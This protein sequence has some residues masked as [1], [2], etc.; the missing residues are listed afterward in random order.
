MEI[1]Y[2]NNIEDLVEA[3][4]YAFKHSKASIIFLKILTYILPILLCFYALFSNVS[5]FYKVLLLIFSIIFIYFY[6]KLFLTQLK[7]GFRKRIKK[8]YEKITYSEQTLIINEKGI[9][10][11]NDYSSNLYNWASVGEII[12]LDKQLLIYLNSMKVI[13]IPKDSF[14]SANELSEFL[15]YLNTHKL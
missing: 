3:N 4:M 13:S 7:K 6:P 2:R 9:T 11:I 5:M 8:D 1:K 15:T 12:N 10:K 14:K